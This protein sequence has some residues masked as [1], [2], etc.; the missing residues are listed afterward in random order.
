MGVT[1]SEAS[2][3]T[4]VAI[5]LSGVSPLIYSP[6]SNVYGRRPV[7]VFSIVI[8]IIASAGSAVATKWSHLLV[9]RVFVGIGSSVGSGIGASTVSDMYF[10]HQRGRYVR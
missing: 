2:Y 4:T 8:G 6:L 1:I 3:Q 9:A 5:I 10:M 7:Y